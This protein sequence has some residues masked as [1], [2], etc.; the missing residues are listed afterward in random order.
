[1][2]VVIYIIIGPLREK[3]CLRCLQTTKAQTSLRIC[4][5]WSAPLLFVFESIISKLATSEI[6]IFRIDSVAE[7]LV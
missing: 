1:M 4:T 2:N 7:R 6:S 3:T 5:D